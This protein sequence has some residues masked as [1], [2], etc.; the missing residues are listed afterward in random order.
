MD[1]HLLYPFL[2]SLVGS[3]DNDF[4]NKLIEYGG[5]Q[6]LYFGVLFHRG[7]EAVKDLFFVEMI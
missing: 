5:C 4:L 3:V 6:F 1:F 7:K 2:T